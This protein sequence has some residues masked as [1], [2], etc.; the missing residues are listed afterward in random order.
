[1]Q[2]LRGHGG[3][4]P[5]EPG[6]RAPRTPP[7]QPAQH[8][9]RISST[10][11]SSCATPAVTRPR[12]RRATTRVSPPC[13]GSACC[14]RRAATSRTSWRCARAS[15]GIPKDREFFDLFEEA[16]RTSCARRICS[17]RCSRNPRERR[18]RPRHPD[19]R[20]GGRPDH[21][22]HHPSAEP[23]VRHADR[24]R[25]HL[26]AGA[27]RSTTSS[28]TPRRSRT[29]W[30][31]TRSRRRWSRRSG[32]PH[33]LLQAARQIAEGDAAAARRFKDISTTPSRSTG[34][35]TTATG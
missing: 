32:W 24:P 34:S 28:T 7:R 26:R 2:V 9:R 13:D 23:D 20:A 22:R 31:S 29:S 30:G 25:G 3:T 15:A 27:R 1:M 33:I 17:T 11:P 21:A 10:S 5:G 4:G 35:R 6:A 8:R 16:G 14:P 12:P 18:T 19:L